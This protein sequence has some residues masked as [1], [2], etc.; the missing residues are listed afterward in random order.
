MKR[1]AAL[2]IALFLLTVPLAAWA[3][4]GMPPVVVDDAGLLTDEEYDQLFTYAEEVSIRQAT[5][6]VVVTVNSLGGKTPLNY[7]ADYFDYNGYGQGDDKA[8]IMLLLSMGERQWATLTTGW[9]IDVFSDRI[10]EE[11]EGDFKPFLSS[12]QYYEAFRC[13]VSLSDMCLT[14]ANQADVPPSQL[15]MPDFDAWRDEYYHLTPLSKAMDDAPYLAVIALVIT[16]IVLIVMYSKMKSARP[17]R[18]ARNYVRGGSLNVTR[19]REI[20][21]YHT[22]TRVKVE[23]ESSGG[24]G[25]G[26][27]STFTS[28]SGSSHGGRSGSF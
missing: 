1:I 26:G 12:G 2:F 7:A 5:D 28:S 6:V 27:S 22:Q 17:Q 19:S 18:G 11:M 25:R 24:G 3:E 20:F 9:A 4:G 23:S 10:L 8:G 21:L 13:F 15:P 14:Q 16:V